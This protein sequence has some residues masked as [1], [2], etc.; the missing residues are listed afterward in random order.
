M[1]DPVHT[2][3]LLQ[4]GKHQYLASNQIHRCEA[5]FIKNWNS[6]LKEIHRSR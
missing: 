5:R 1:K 3:L 2:F 6:T 4:G